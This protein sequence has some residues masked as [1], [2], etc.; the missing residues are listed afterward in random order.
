[1]TARHQPTPGDDSL[2]VRLGPG[3]GDEALKE[4][5]VKEFD[6]TDKAMKGWVLVGPGG[7]E[8]DEQLGYWIR[9][10]ARF[11]GTLPTQ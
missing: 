8:D 6:I 11:V 1:V 4:P 5:H 9:R 2:V 10:A 3:Q 7:I